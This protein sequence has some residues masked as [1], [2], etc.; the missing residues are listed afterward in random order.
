MKHLFIRPLDVWLF[1]NGKSF[2]A[3]SDHRAETV[4]PP[5]P[6]VLQG[7]IRTHY[8]EL[9]GGIPAYLHGQLPDVITKI[10]KKGEPPPA[11]FQI[12]GGFLAQYKDKQLTC[13]VPL[14][15]HVYLD[16]DIYRLLEPEKKSG[17]MTDLGETQ[18]LLWRD[19][20]VAATKSDGSGWLSLTDLEILLNQKQLPKGSEDNPTVKPDCHFFERESRL[21][22]K[23]DYQSHTTETGQLYQTESVRLR[24]EYGLYVELD[25]VD[26]PDNGIFNLGGEAH[27][28][29]YETIAPLTYPAPIS[30]GQNNF[31]VTF[32]TP[33]Y[34]EKGWQPASWQKFMGDSANFVT[35][36][37]GKPLVLGGF[38][39]AHKRHKASRRYVPAGSTYY[40]TGTPN[41]PST[42]K[43]MCDEVIENKIKFNYGQYGFGQFILGAW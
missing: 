19:K 40:F 25:G 29:L 35:A 18:Q 34:F 22:I 33:T 36:A 10:G 27:A 23:L 21:G 39:V 14:P 7:A 5:L 37:M 32:L 26:W 13:Y 8:I 31:T 20:H 15:A 1:R 4:F 42:I 30:P 11:S 43:T 6:T 41:I 16:D 3:G 12:R 28:A 38:D 17:V 2:N 24:E 9:H